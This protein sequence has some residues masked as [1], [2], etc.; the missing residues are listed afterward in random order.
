M[1]L[2]ALEPRKRDRILHHG[3]VVHLAVDAHPRADAQEGVHGQTASVPCCPRRGQHVVRAA[4]I[5][6]QHLSGIAPHEQPPVVRAL[7]PD[8]H[9]ILGHDLE[10]L[11]GDLVAH[12]DSILDARCKHTEALGDSRSGRLPVW[13]GQV[14]KLL[15]HLCVDSVDQPLAGRHQDGAGLDIVL[16]LRKKVRGNGSGVCRVISNHKHLRGPRKHVDGSPA[17]R[18]KALGRCHPLVARPNDDVT[19]GHWANALRE[20]GHRLR[21]PHLEQAVGVG[22]V[23]SRH[24]DLVGVGRCHPHVLHT[25][26]ARRASRHEHT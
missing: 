21:P 18:H 9:R 7:H 19:L 24:R 26:H 1:A 20:G 17:L 16:R 11:R 15:G 8:L 12:S 2:E 22:H 14:R 6:P 10:V 23:R 3:L 4:S 5:V 13:G 25:C